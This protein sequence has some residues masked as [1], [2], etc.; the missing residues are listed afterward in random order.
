MGL[1]IEISFCGVSNDGPSIE[2]STDC[3]YGIF[4][5]GVFLKSFQLI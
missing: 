1:N 2:A 5:E 4:P 3:M